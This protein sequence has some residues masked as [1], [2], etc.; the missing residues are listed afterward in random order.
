MDVFARGA[1]DTLVHRWFTNGRWSRWE[2]LGGSLTSAPAVASW[3]PGRLD[4]FARGGRGELRQRSFV[5][6]RGWLPWRG[7][8]G[9]LSSSPAATSWAPG[10]IDVVARGVGDTL[11]HRYLVTGVGWSPWRTR[12]AGLRSQPAI[13]SPGAGLLD[14]T[15]RRSGS[16]MWIRRFVRGDGWTGWTS[17]GGTFSSGPSATARGGQV[18]V[19][20]RR[21]TGRLAMTIRPAPSASWRRWIGIDPL[22]PFRRLSTW[23]D[24]FDYASLD[25]DA[26]VADMAARGVRT[27]FLSTARF[28]STS[29]FHDAAEAG[30]WLDAA[31]AAGVKVVGWYPPAYGDMA[32]DVRRTI[33]IAEFASPGGQR[34][35]A[36]G[37]DIERLDEVTRAQF[38]IRLVDHLTRVR[39]G[40]D[41]MLA[42]IV[43]SPFATDPGNNWEGFPWSAVGRRSDVVVP[44]AL[45]SFRDSCPGTE[46]CPYTPGQ[47]Y[48]W[49]LDQTRRARTLT[50]RPVTVEGGV[51]DPGAENTPVTAPRVSRFV[52]AVIDG[53]AI[54]G[55]HYDYRTTN[56]SLWP[57]LARLNDL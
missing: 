23:V 43:P 35:D 55:S 42:A 5:S 1:D 22:Q 2:S 26:A 18:L 3:G 52:D 54:G 25:P 24:V 21:P 40:T 51:D 48:T 49:V 9:T 20:A 56:A 45:W 17:L 36:V 50:G 28:T 57:T 27:L 53:G 39:A 46:V 11:L 14:I 6:G 30:A 10:R 37:I 8:G 32:R 41:T 31:H 16:V 12:S 19:M 33:A 44:M 15:A 7:R 34:F 47:V 29:D 38:N 13:A 4:V